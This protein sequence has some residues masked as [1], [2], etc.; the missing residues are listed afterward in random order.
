MPA[1]LK[2]RLDAHLKTY[3]LHQ[4]HLVC[5]LIDA[6]LKRVAEKFNGKVGM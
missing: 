5:A 1:G 6:H 3:G 4:E 2:R